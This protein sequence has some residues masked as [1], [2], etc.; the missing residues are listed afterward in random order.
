MYVNPMPWAA[1]W[2][3]ACCYAGVDGTKKYT[4][5]QLVANSEQLT[6]HQIQHLR[7]ESVWYSNYDSKFRLASQRRHGRHA[8]GQCSPSP[9][10]SF[11]I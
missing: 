6:L 7:L 11:W 2:A 3:V 8:D 10:G 1:V 9:S 4:H 5:S